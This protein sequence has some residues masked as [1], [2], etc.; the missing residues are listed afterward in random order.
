MVSYKQGNKAPKRK[1]QPKLN[2]MKQSIYALPTYA[3]VNLGEW[4]NRESK[5]LHFEYE[6]EFK[7]KPLHKSHENEQTEHPE[8][9]SDEK[10][11][12]RKSINMQSKNPFTK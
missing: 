2:N 3:N 11:K 4:S 9:G 10:S 5:S 12:P 6:N 8:K 1:R 7:T